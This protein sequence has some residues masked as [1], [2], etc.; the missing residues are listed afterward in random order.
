LVFS[1]NIFLFW[2]FPITLAGYYLLRKPFRNTFLLIMSLLF[3]AWGE[4]DFV[5]IMIGSIVFNYGVALLADS[6]RQK[7]RLCKTILVFCVAGNLG[8]LFV[9][10]Y[11]DFFIGNINRFGLKLPLFELALPIGISFFTF[12]AMSY[13]IDVYRGRVQPQRKPQDFGLYLSFFPQ[14]I[15][16][17]IIRYQAVQEQIAA[18]K[19]TF[20][21]FSEGVHRFLIG[22]NKKILLANN[23]ALIADRAFATP[24]AERSVIYAWLGIIAY[25]FQILFDFSGYSDMAIGLGRMFGFK[26]AEN[27]NYPYIS[28]SLSEFWRRWHISLGLWFRDYVYFPLSGSLVKKKWGLRSTYL[29]SSLVVWFLTGLWHGASFN[30]VIWGLVHFVLIAFEMISGYPQK[31]KSAFG[32]GLYQIFTLL[33]VLGGWVIFRAPGLKA[34]VTY[35][36]SMLAL[37]GNPLFCDGVILTFREYWLFLLFSLLCS[38]E[39]FKRLKMYPFQRGVRVML[40]TLSVGFYMFCFIWSVSFLIL[41][42]HNPFIYFNF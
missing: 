33:C 1:S 2:F 30:F 28:A 38:T 13:V 35:G 24:D 10:K 7:K 4:P 16:G 15:A 21:L 9:Y 22:I 6:C 31:F 37:R 19:E 36:L 27:F 11:L 17:P 25:A 39:L 8:L 41:G 5:F 18:R 20:D 32:K 29:V 3:Y 12:Q 23:M 40:N 42:A 14:L 34:A 26:F